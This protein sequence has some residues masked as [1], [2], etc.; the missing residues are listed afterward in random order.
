MNQ[1]VDMLN[2]LN[3]KNKDY[4]LYGNNIAKININTQLFSN[5]KGKLILLTSINPTPA[6]EG[7]TTTAIGLVDG[8]NLLNKQAVLALREPSLGPVF[9][10]KGSA[11]GGGESVV[12][13]EEKI[14]LHFTGDNHAITS[15]NNL[16]SSAIDN[17]IY[18]KSSLDIDP[19]RIIWKRC[20]DLNDR[21][22]REVEI[23]VS[24]TITRKEQFTITA[25]SSMMTILTLSISE[26]D[27]RE[28]IETSLVGYSKTGKEIFVSDLKITGAVMA[29]LKDVIKPNFVLTK[30]NSPV[31]IHCGPFANISIGTNSILSTKLAL[32]LA[33]YAVI[34]TGFGSDLGFE[35]FMNLI[36]GSVD[37]IP[38]CVV[39]VVT[40]RALQLHNDFQNNFAH[41][42]QHLK[43]IKLYNLNLVVAIN[44]IEGDDIVQLQQL[45]DWLTKN[46]FFWAVNKAYTD[47]PVGAVDLASL[48]IKQADVKI[49]YKRLINTTDSIT[50]KI[51]KIVKH[52]YYLNKVVF[53]DKAKKIIDEIIDTK[54]EKYP[55]CIVK[56]HASID[57][58]DYDIKDYQLKIENIEI[59]TGGRFILVYT[60]KIFTMP[61]LNKNPN[62][63]NIDLINDEIIGIK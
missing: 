1:I 13:P 62:Y 44:Y 30:Y 28:R 6:G 48:V 35:K 4:D 18:W 59:N 52:F 21:S 45:Q 40:L 58:N 19:Q 47:G 53:S 56:S 9:G 10:Q 42:H 33:D 63:Q 60:N 7:K 24:K 23:K 34:E 37:L 49:E 14:N 39:M 11:S 61:G 43:H 29:L 31:L 5:K 27:L 25:A 50:K 12:I 36:N 41:L 22:L 20:L 57:G 2:K 26:A 32:S 8:L 17:E 38:D 51:E 3:L 16:I 15:A 54:Y 55:I 46:N